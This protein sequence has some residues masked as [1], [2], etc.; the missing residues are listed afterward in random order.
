MTECC[1]SRDGHFFVFTEKKAYASALGTHSAACAHCDRNYFQETVDWQCKFEHSHNLME[2][3]SPFDRTEI[4]RA[5]HIHCWEE[6]PQ[7]VRNPKK[8][9]RCNAKL[10]HETDSGSRDCEFL[11]RKEVKP[12]PAH[13]QTIEVMGPT[14]DSINVFPSASSRLSPFEIA[15]GDTKNAAKKCS[16]WSNENY[17]PENDSFHVY[18]VIE[19]KESWV[20]FTCSDFTGWIQTSDLAKF[21]FVDFK[22]REPVCFSSVEAAPPAAAGPSEKKD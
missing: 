8:L 14:A 22:T 19:R 21:K 3:S 16:L 9:W 2:T 13:W 12:M 6:V 4:R 5:I 15:I 18:H 11:V 10:V 20:R 1:G 7:K 17:N